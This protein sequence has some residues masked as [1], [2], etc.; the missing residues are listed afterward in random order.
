MVEL[1]LVLLGSSLLAR[2][3]GSPVVHGWISTC[4]VAEELKMSDTDDAC[5][6]WLVST[7]ADLFVGDADPLGNS[8][9]T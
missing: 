5:E 7:S 3:K 6:W 1:D 4:D 8:Q 9:T 2:F